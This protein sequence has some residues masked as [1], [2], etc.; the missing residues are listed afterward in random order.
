MGHTLCFHPNSP[1]FYPKEIITSQGSQLTEDLQALNLQCHMEPISLEIHPGTQ[2]PQL[3]LLH[4]NYVFKGALALPQTQGHTPH[5]V[6]SLSSCESQCKAFP[7]YN[8]HRCALYHTLQPTP[9]PQP[10]H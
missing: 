10:F 4:F 2:F 5:L 1:E 7:D 9:A 6:D 8:M 3:P